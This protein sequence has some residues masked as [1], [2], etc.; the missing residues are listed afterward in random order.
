LILGAILASL[1]VLLFLGNVRLMIIAALAIP[2][3]ILSTFILM[4]ILGYTLNYMTLLALTLA[5]G[6]VID[7]AV[8]V[9]ENIW[10]TME[11]EGLPPEQAS[12]QGM[13]EIGFA[14]LATTVSLV[15]LFMP[16]SI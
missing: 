5:V 13:K 4:D 14:V 3:S 2:V 11:E 15:V 10:R 9:L 1:M 7:D 12:V 16:L 6:L 8:V